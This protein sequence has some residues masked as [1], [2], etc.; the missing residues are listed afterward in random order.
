MIWNKKQNIILD[1][2]L[3]YLL[4]IWNESERLCFVVILLVQMLTNFCHTFS[5][6]SHHSSSFIMD[7]GLGTE[8]KIQQI[9]LIGITWRILYCSHFSFPAMSHFL[10]EMSDFFLN[11]PQ[12]SEGIFLIHIRIFLDLQKILAGALCGEP[13]L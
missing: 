10:S 11:F 2:F 7:H 13:L 9:L 1:F 4:I 8:I 12:L 3:Y 5:E 6:Q